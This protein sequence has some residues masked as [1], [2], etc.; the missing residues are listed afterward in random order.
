MADPV[1]PPGYQIVQPASASGVPPPP[2]GYQLVNPAPDPKSVAPQA[3]DV[4]QGDG[5]TSFT[6]TRSAAPLSAADQAADARVAK[7][8]AAGFKPQPY[9]AKGL[10]FGSYLDE[11]SAGID[12]GLNAITGGR[13]GQPYENALAYQHAR[14]RYIEKNL[15]GEQT[16]ASIAGG[17]G[18]AGAF[19]ALNLIKGGSLLAD[20]ANALLTA[21]GY[22]G[23][24]GS[25]DDSGEGRVANALSGAKDAMMF[26]APLYPIA[27]VGGNALATKLGANPPLP[28]ELQS[29]DPRAV[30]TAA[31]LFSEDQLGLPITG[32][33]TQSNMLGP[34]AM[35]MD[36]GPN[37]RAVG[38]ALTKRTGPEM[39]TAVKTLS[40]RAKGAEGRIDDAINA[41][42][43]KPVNVPQTI[44]QM[45]AA[46]QA[47]AKPLYDAFR[48]T[49]IKPTA[50]LGNILDR[51][52]AAGAYDTAAKLAAQDGIDVSQASN[53]G[54]FIDLIKRGLDSKIETA[55]RAGDA[56][57]VRSL[58]GIASD[59]RNE[60]DAILRSQGNVARDAAGNVLRDPKTGLPLSIYQRARQVAGEHLKL[61]DAFEKGQKAFDKNL[62]AEQMAYNMRRMSPEERQMFRMGART[63]IRNVAEN[64]S[65]KAGANPD[66]AERRMLQSRNAQKKLSMIA[67]RP[68]AARSLTRTLE[69]ETRFDNTAQKALQNSD[70]ALY[71]AAQKRVPGDIE[72]NSNLH[73]LSIEGA[74]A[75]TTKHIID[76][77]TSNGL[78]ARNMRHAADLMR[79]LTA[80][81]VSRDQIII[82]LNKVIQSRTLSPAQRAAAYQAA[83]KLLTIGTVAPNIDA[84]RSVGQPT[85]SASP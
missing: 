2:P 81:G 54:L 64:A 75:V 36:M 21:A 45:Q 34:Q 24:Y 27:R 51:A 3:S 8:A 73:N 42:M 67:D 41:A 63:Q 6:L 9:A 85:M 44:E 61:S 23:L 60:T 71:Q 16:A 70:T 29:F 66:T 28:T 83:A 10:P 15:P 46:K 77:V 22:G 79:M 31:D 26:A 74:I 47:A 50:S 43:G 20:G 52:K 49:P 69:A 62:S 17:I 5:G 11:A 55:M 76:T 84:R 57:Q 80:Q 53:N 48:A 82:G 32:A 56:T 35:L 4:S 58:S 65:T 33:Q 59:L 37:N 19:P 72:F 25:G 40:Q 13:I 30:K 1:P 12:A 18:T 39:T 7:E 78:T 14:D 38:A 68:A